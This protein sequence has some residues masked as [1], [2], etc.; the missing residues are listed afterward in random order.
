MLYISIKGL[1]DS[2]EERTLSSPEIGLLKV[3]NYKFIDLQLMLSFGKGKKL[4]Q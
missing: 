3:A 2:E 4:Q 1:Y